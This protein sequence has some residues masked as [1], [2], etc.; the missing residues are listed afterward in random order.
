MRQLSLSLL[1]QWF[2]F[3]YPRDAYAGKIHQGKCSIPLEQD[4]K[5]QSNVL[6]SMGRDGISSSLDFSPS[7]HCSE[8]S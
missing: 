2:R 6:I 4:Q 3:R 8:S 5:K 7:F 1:S